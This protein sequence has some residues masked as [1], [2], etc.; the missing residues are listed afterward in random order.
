MPRPILHHAVAAR[1]ARTSRWYL[2]D[3]LDAFPGVGAAPPPNR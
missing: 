3:G 1:G 2:H